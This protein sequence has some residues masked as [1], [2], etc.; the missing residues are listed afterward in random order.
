LRTVERVDGPGG[1]TLSVASVQEAFGR[2]LKNSSR[3]IAIEEYDPTLW[4]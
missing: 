4:V 3:R 2:D 1:F